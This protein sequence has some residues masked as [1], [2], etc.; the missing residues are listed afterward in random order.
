MH[1]LTG[2]VLQKKRSKIDCKEAL[3]DHPCMQTIEKR[4]LLAGHNV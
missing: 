3:P 4:W 2:L 1:N